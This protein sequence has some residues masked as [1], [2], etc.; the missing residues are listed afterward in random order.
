MAQLDPK[1]VWPGW[2]TTRLIGRGSFG[3]VYEIERDVFGE[4]EKAALKLITIPQSDS[5]IEELRSDGYDAESITGTFHNYLRSIVAE[6]SLMRKLNGSANV[7]NCDDVRYVQHE[8]GIGWDIFIKMELLTPLTKALREEDP[9]AQALALGADICRA[10]AL[11]RKHDIVHRD[12]KPANVFVSENGDYKLGDFGVAKTVE[13]TT[14]GTKIG[15]YE[16]MAPEVYHD[17]PYGSGADIYSLGLVLYWLL[18][19]RRTPFLPLPPAV[20]TAAEKEQARRRRFSGEPLPP[21]K[22]GSAALKQIVLKACAYEPRERY[23]SAEEMLAALEALRSKPAPQANAAEAYTVPPGAYAPPVEETTVGMFGRENAR[24]AANGAPRQPVRPQDDG[25]VSLFSDRGAPAGSNAFVRPQAPASRRVPPQPAYAPENPRYPA[26]PP[27][28]EKKRSKA[29]LIIGIAAAAVAVTAAVLVL[30]L[31]ILPKG[32][33]KESKPS[34]PPTVT[35]TEDWKIE[36]AADHKNTLVI[37]TDGVLDKDVFQSLGVQREY[38]RSVRFEGE[39]TEIGAD[40]FNAFSMLDS[41]DIP[42]GVTRIGEHAFAGCDFLERVTIPKSV[43]SI[44]D[45]AFF[46]CGRL[47]RASFSRD[48][49][50]AEAL[51]IGSE[52]FAGCASLEGAGFRGVTDVGPQA[53]QNCTGLTDIY[54]FGDLTSVGIRVFSN[55]TSLSHVEIDDGVTSI[56][57]AAF[58]NSGLTSVTIAE[59][60]TRIQANAFQGCKLTDVYYRGSEEQWDAIE[61]D[62]SGNDALRTATIHFNVIGM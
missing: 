17:Q 57:G 60:V 9:Q 1:A 35:E 3:A 6:Y 12:I 62:A 28:P 4:T 29:G 34:L 44:G 36:T 10:L 19:E 7:V 54:S 61:M 8:D 25:T 40:A 42:E 14:G 16:Y 22:N 37:Y 41:I 18:N 32:A 15:T 55:C 26:P 2:T 59:S 11:C 31:L 39:V 33:S 21:P 51:T 30:A 52:A 23:Q 43:T 48:L 47:K 58:E 27:A 50:E 13:K 56:G 5:D 24:P 45:G 20:P 46:C 38:I 53:F 49:N